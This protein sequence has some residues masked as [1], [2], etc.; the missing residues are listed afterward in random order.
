M[1]F[2]QLKRLKNIDLIKIAHVYVY[3]DAIINVSFASD[4]EL[5]VLGSHFMILISYL[6]S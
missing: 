4:L 2:P 1:N 6:I 3:L 5:C